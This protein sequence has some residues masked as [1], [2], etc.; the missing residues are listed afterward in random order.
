[1]RVGDP[2][3]E[4]PSWRNLAPRVGFAWDVF[5]SGKT[6]IRSGYGIFPD[7]LL[8]PYVSYIG[9][10]NSPFFRRGETRTLTTGDFPRRGYQALIAN[11]TPDLAVDRI[12]RDL[13]QPYV[14]QWNFN[15]EQQAGLNNFIRIAYVGSHGLNL[16]SITNDAN[17]VEPVTLADGRLFYPA[18]G[19]AIN[20]T[21]A[22]IRNRQFDAHSFYHGLQTEF[23]RRLANG[24]QAQFTHTFS[25]SI[26]DSSNF[27]SANE[28]P[29]R[30][31]LP[32]NGAPRFN[33]GL[34]GHDVRHYFTAGV[35]WDLPRIHHP[36]WNRVAGGW[37][38][39]T[40][41][42]YASGLPTTAWLAYDAARTKTHMS[43]ASIG[44]RPDLAPGATNNPVTGDPQRWVDINAFRR[45]EPG[46]HGNLGRNTISGPDLATVDFSMTR[47][48]GLAR[49]GESAA[50]DLRFEFFNLLNRTN[51]DLPAVERMETFTDTSVRED[52]GR[53][54]SAGKSRE[55]QFGA[56]LR[57]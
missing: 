9:V 43:G 33:R 44:Q 51:L 31:V 39:G 40:I 3:Y 13:R 20:S 38:M 8:S 36:E 54:T 47:Q 45:P 34:S 14:Q 23:R 2:L 50:L 56:K 57:F 17:L 15:V 4:D 1:M 7:L 22:G 28:S 19:K 29:N 55:I 10:R 16:S 41:V 18:E 37:Q 25:K 27:Y 46:F 6:L 52:F 48:F 49:L 32:L 26:D 21:F 11:P 12:P 30:G 35:T 24:L 5:G 42:V 53:I